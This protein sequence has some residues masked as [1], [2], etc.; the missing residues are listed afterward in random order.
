MT[1]NLAKQLEEGKAYSGLQLASP[2][3]QGGEVLG[4]EKE[5]ASHRTPV[6]WKW[7]VVLAAV[8]DISPANSVA[9]I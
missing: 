8:Q 9:H 7:S 1:E 5:V 2:V 3:R 6:V 4:Q